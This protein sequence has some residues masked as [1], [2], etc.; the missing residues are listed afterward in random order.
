[1]DDSLTSKGSILRIKAL[2]MMPVRL[3]RIVEVL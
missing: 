2:E 3:V 1:M